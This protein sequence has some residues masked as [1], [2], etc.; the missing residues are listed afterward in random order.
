MPANIAEGNGRLHRGDYLRFI[1]I[2][3]GSLMELDT[4]LELARRTHYLSD[5]ELAKPLALIDHIGRMLTRLAK[6]ISPSAL[7]PR[8]ERRGP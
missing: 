6:A 4:H 5:Q 2:A 1:S 8:A 3:R 7:P